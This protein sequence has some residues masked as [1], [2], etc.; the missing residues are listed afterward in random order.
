MDQA[1]HE[2]HGHPTEVQRGTI[3]AGF[4]GALQDQQH[5][6]AEQQGEQPRIRP[7]MKVSV[8]TQRAISIGRSPPQ[9]IGLE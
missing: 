4:I 7:L 1:Q 5:G 8:K 3:L 6:G 2:Q 9:A